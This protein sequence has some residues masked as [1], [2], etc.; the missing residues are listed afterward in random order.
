VAATRHGI[1]C[2]R[3]SKKIREWVQDQGV[4]LL[5]RESVTATSGGSRIARWQCEMD[6]VAYHKIEA[7]WQN[8]DWAL[9]FEDE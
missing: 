9:V 1:I 7:H 8:L 5:K 2:F 4:T 6:E 3:N